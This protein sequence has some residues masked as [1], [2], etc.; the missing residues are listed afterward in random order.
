MRQIG[1]EG[2]IVAIKNID[3]H[4]FLG[5]KPPLGTVD[6]DGN[7]TS[8]ALAT[9]CVAGTYKK[10]QAVMGAFEQLFGK[11]GFSRTGSQEAADSNDVT[12]GRDRAKG[13]QNVT[14]TL[15]LEKMY[16]DNRI[17]GAVKGKWNHLKRGYDWNPYFRRYEIWFA[18]GPDVPTL[19]MAE[20]DTLVKLIGVKLEQDDVDNKNP[21]TYR[22]PI[23]VKKI[24]EF[25]NWKASE[26]AAQHLKVDWTIVEKTSCS[27]T[28]QPQAMLQTRLKFT[29]AS[30]TTYGVLRISGYN[31]FGER[32][33]EEVDLSSP[34][35]T[36]YI[37]KEYF[38][39]VDTNGVYVGAGWAGSTPKL[40]I[41]EYD[42]DLKP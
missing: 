30:T 34:K 22:I 15:D 26:W 5:T 4:D 1:S 24:Q 10:S 32:V 16:L 38:S 18:Y 20:C 25:P 31:I 17:L 23:F 21:V 8:E 42:T 35:P 37:T 2:G 3:P 33:V 11:T 40:S 41:D 7:P 39:S 14:G 29:F 12:T 28:T 13:F 9:T 19:E 27:L 6:E 36:T